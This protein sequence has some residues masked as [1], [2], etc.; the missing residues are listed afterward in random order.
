MSAQTMTVQ[1]VLKVKQLVE[2]FLKIKHV[3]STSPISLN[4][5]KLTYKFFKPSPLTKRSHEQNQLRN[6]YE[7]CRRLTELNCQVDWWEGEIHIRVWG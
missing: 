2:S 3:S 5:W 7:L 6:C 4:G 1:K